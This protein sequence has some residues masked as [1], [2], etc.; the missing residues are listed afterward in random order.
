MIIS[1]IY[2]I[3][4]FLTC[5]ITIRGVYHIASMHGPESRI[6]TISP[7]L[8]GGIS[9]FIILYIVWLDGFPLSY[10]IIAQFLPMLYLLVMV[11]KPVLN[12]YIKDA[13]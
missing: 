6:K 7:V 2:I 9:R 10:A 8:I 11:I 4:Y 13:A 3:L 1:L 12:D 5:W